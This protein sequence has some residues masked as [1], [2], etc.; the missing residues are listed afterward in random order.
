MME[1]KETTLI[2]A[3]NFMNVQPIM[4][5]LPYPQTKV[6]GK[7][8]QY[9]NLLSV[10]LCG[11]VSEMSAITQY[12]NNESRLSGANCPMA[13]TVLGIAMAEMIHLQKLAEL[14][15]LLGGTVDYVARYRDGQQKIWTPKYITMADHTG[16]ILRA[17]IESELQAIRQY[18]MH[19]KMIKDDDI[20]AVL[21]RI[22]TD[23]E[24]HIMLLK[25]YA[26]KRV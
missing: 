18:R 2:N 15:L 25:S 22:I 7:N 24:Y 17:G 16:S 23:E 26:Q 20:N 14:I 13:Q 3:C 8:Q 1:E 21:A 10:D 11:A 12:I 9:A 19:M 6:Q 5:D 4:A